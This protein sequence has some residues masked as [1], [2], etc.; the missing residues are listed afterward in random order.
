ML[1]N[2]LLAQNVGIG[3]SSPD[4]SAKLDV[5]SNNSGLLVPRMTTAERNAIP[6]PAN[7][8]LIFN[9]DTQC[10]QF[11]DAPSS[12]WINLG[13]GCV[14]P[15]VP[16]ANAAS[17][18]TTSGFTANWTSVSG[19][20]NYFLDVAL[21][22]GFTNFVTGYNNLNVGN[23]VSYNVTG[24]TCGTT[25]YYRVR[26]NGCAASSNSNVITA[27]SD[28]C[29]SSF[30]FT[31]GGNQNEEGRT[32]I[33]TSDGGYAIAGYTNSFGSG[34]WDFYVV[35][36][37]ATKSIQWTRTVGG[38]G[39]DRT[40]PIYPM[41]VQTTDG[42]YVLSGYTYGSGSM[43]I[44][45]VKLNSWGG[46]QWTRVIGND[47]FSRSIIKTSD[48]D[49]L[50]VGNAWV[51]YSRVNDICIVKL[52]GSGTL[53]WTK[54]VG[55]SLGDGGD[56][57]VQTSDGGYLV[58][59]HTYSYGAG[60]L[61]I[62]IAK[63]DA[64]GELE[65]TRTVG[66]SGDD[67]AY[68][69]IQTSDG[70]YAIAGYT[71]SF[72]A[73]GNDMYIVKLNGSGGLEWTRTVGGSGNDGASSIIQESDGSYMVSGW[74]ESFGAGGRDFYIVRLDANGNACASC[75]PNSGG[76]VGSGGIVG[77]GGTQV[78]LTPSVS[79]GGSISSG[80]TKNII[81]N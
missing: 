73:G 76:S 5:T 80:G 81:C 29:V 69:I 24:L 12:T 59:G 51:S 33:Q 47:V 63:L 53:Q 79:S 35:K 27:S 78:I 32:I 58:L 34:D 38:T 37:D 43:K 19:A 14:P 70:G 11:W 42:G 48:G 30:C 28:V 23:V 20:T 64:S 62:Y 65:W 41:I 45:I 21:D 68:S 71:N 55:G 49:F 17:G 26:A 6:S 60:D 31:I 10:Y 9:T 75:N 18:I 50:V 16:T 61:D 52:D 2:Q 7:S 77:S 13:C 25:Y 74:T 1:A 22:A 4:A 57:A 39:E 3:T 67:N 44:Y 40:F 72:G 46:I 15:G 66:G 54:T 36:L 56:V 8:L